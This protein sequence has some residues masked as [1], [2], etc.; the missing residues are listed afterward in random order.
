MRP[1]RMHNLHVQ[2]DA[3]TF[4]FLA[5]PIKI[6]HVINEESPFWNMTVEQLLAADFEV[7][8]VLEGT[9]QT[10]GQTTQVR[11]SYLPGEILWGQRLNTLFTSVKANNRFQVDYTRFHDA[12]PVDM[13]EE[14]AAA[15]A[16]EASVPRTQFD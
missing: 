6:T 1:F 13:S 2:T 5:W 11:T 9:N 15:F 16:K 3:E 8:V 7:V 10:T 4:F 12:E 14:S